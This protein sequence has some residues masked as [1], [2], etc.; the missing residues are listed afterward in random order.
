MFEILY[1][2]EGA[3]GVLVKVSVLE[4]MGVLEQMCIGANVYWR[5]LYW[6]KFV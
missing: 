6:R 5:K 3:L 2:L 1:V 4:K